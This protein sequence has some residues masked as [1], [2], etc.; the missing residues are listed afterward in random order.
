MKKGNP[1]KMQNEK[2]DIIEK[3][4]EIIDNIENLG[5]NVFMVL[6]RLELPTERIFSSVSEKIKVFK[7]LEDVVSLIENE[8]KIN[9]FYISKFVAAVAA[10]LFDAALNYLWDETI[11]QLRLRVLKYDLDYFFDCA[12]KS[13]KRKELKDSNDIVKVDDHELLN[14]AKDIGLINYIGYNHLLH[15]KF[16]RNWV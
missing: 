14:G 16:M 10:G 9:S 1:I 8:K 15:I 11:L 7:N 4:E 3:K 12:V 6:E 2:Q 5:Q 13:V